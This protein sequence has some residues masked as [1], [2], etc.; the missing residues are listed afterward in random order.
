MPK[1]YYYHYYYYIYY[2]LVCAQAYYVPTS[3]GFCMK[4]LMFPTPVPPKSYE[5]LIMVS[6]ID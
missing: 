3:K 6:H 4:Y 1:L 2:Q 5:F